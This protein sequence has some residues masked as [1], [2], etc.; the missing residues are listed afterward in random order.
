MNAKEKKIDAKKIREEV[1]KTYAEAISRKNLSCCSSLEETC[2]ATKVKAKDIGYSE[3]ELGNLPTDSTIT[4]FGCGNPLAYSEVREGDVVLDLG[5]GA[6]LDLLIAARKVGPSGQVIGVDMTEEMINKAKENI[7][8]AGVKNVEVRKGLIEDLPI[9]SSS[10][11]WVISNCVIN[12][13]PEKEKVFSEITRVL[14]PGGRM[15]VSDMVGENIPEWLRENKNLYS[16]CIS[17]VI[18]EKEY[19]SGL[20]KAGL[21]KVKV[22]ERIVYQSDELES[23]IKLSDSLSF[24]SALENE[25]EFELNMV[26]KRI[27]KELEGKVASVKISAYKPAL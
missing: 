22:S 26:V 23:L 5:P 15:V 3:D 13:S 14:K 8:A 12:L 20:R 4:T 18:S 24:F 11:D 6:G 17:G 16:A 7:K 10:V 2:C 25:K 27:V 21:E 19:L 1:K 9:E